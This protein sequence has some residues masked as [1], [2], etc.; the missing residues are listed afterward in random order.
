MPLDSKE[1]VS[2]MRDLSIRKIPGIGRVN[3]RLL[4]SIGVKVCYGS[5]KLP[6]ESDSSRQTCHDIYT[7]RATIA[8]MD[9]QFGLTYLLRTYLGIA[10]NVVEPSRREERKS[11]GHERCKS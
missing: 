10:S 4:E 1:I 8:V 7:N 5:F 3:E 9:K 6:T 11:I 2:F